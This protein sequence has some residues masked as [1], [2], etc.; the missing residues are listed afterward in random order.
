MCFKL[1][2]VS[3][4]FNGFLVFAQKRYTQM[5]FALLVVMNLQKNVS[6]HVSCTSVLSAFAQ[7]IA[8]SMTSAPRNSH[9]VYQVFKKSF[10]SYGHMLPWR[11]DW[12]F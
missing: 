9:A 11:R 6:L 3:T 12:H 5:G 1:N 4:I 7:C 8:R 10:F 2:L